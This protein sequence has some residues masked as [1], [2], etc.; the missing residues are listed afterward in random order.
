MYTDIVLRTALTTPKS[1]SSA[2]A[3]EFQACVFDWWLHDYD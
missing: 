1:L 2:K 3:P